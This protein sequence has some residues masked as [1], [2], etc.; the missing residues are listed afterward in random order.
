MNYSLIEDAYIEDIDINQI[1]NYEE[2]SSS[3]LLLDKEDNITDAN[4]LISDYKKVKQIIDT[5]RVLLFELEKQKKD[6]QTYKSNIFIQHQEIMIN[7]NKEISNINNPTD[8]TDINDTIIKYIDCIKN[9]S[10]KWLNNHYLINKTKLERDI[11][12]NEKKLLSFNNL[13]IKTTNEIIKTEKMNKKL[14]PICFENETDM[15]AIPCGH[16]C[17][18]TCV[19]QSNNYGNLKRCLSCRNEIKQYIKIY[20]LL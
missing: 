16:T 12:I 4:K 8:T 19:I 5:S 2:S 15:C 9:F 6:I 14:C 3:D 1:I 10:D 11:E 17:C 13:F 7:L 20:F 18:N